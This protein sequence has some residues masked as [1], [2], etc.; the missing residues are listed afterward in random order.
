MPPL[1][2]SLALLLPPLALRAA[3]PLPLLEDV[4]AAV[5][6]VARVCREQVHEGRGQVRLWEPGE[7]TATLLARGAGGRRR[8]AA[9]LV[10][11]AQRCTR[12]PSALGE[13]L[14]LTHRCRGAASAPLL[15]RGRTCLEV[16]VNVQSPGALAAGL[17]TAAAVA[18]RSPERLQA[19]P[20][21]A[22][23][24]QPAEPT[25]ARK[26]AHLRCALSSLRPS[27]V[28]A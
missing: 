18:C 8:R 11:P 1:R 2:D 15:Q 13:L 22:R 19:K 4:M 9:G 17:A 16:S 27:S 12:C 14:G 10:R 6:G 3:E 21:P 5:A 7:P 24:W 20:R 25:G 28:G 26:H 23:S